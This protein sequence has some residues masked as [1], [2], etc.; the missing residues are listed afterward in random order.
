VNV[1]QPEI[2][3]TA[4]TKEVLEKHGLQASGSLVRLTSTCLAPYLSNHKDCV[5]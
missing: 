5:R 4:M 1:S 2:I 3:D